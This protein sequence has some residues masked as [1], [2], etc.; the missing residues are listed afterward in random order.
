MIDKKLIITTIFLFLCLICSSQR[1]KF[2]QWNLFVSHPPKYD[3]GVRN[4]YDTGE[5]AYIMMFFPSIPYRMEKILD[6][7]ELNDKFVLTHV[8]VKR[9][10]MLYVI[11]SI[12]CYHYEIRDSQKSFERY[13]LL[14]EEAN[15]KII[16][17]TH[18]V[19]LYIPYKLQ[20]FFIRMDYY[21][22]S[23]Q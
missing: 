19:P 7:M 5:L 10:E 1:Y 16:P 3:I 21:N 17:N 8:Y 6:S 18:I 23:D 20:E 4:Y 14:E 2:A 12:E 11:D 9:H 22:V 15:K 13:G